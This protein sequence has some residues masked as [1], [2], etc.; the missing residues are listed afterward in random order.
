MQDAKSWE[1]NS[2]IEEIMKEQN[3]KMEKYLDVK[4]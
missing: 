4:K 2:E 1:E 3:K